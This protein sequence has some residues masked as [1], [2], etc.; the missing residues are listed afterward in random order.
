MAFAA[1][2]ILGHGF[3]LLPMMQQLAANGLAKTRDSGGSVI[4]LI[5]HADPVV[6][7]VMGI[8]A[9]ASIWSWAVAI[10]KWFTIQAAKGRAKRFESQFWSGGA[11]EDMSDRVGDK[12]SDAMARIF[13]AGSREYRDAARART[14]VTEPQAN[15]MIERAR[16]QMNVAVQRESTRLESG[17]QTLAIVA[18]SA[19]FI[20][21]FGTVI[22]IMNAFSAIGAQQQ[23]NLAVV[24]PGIAEALL[25]T[26]IGLGAAVPAL[27]F[28]NKF[29]GD[30][31]KFT[32]RL[33]LFAQEFTVR[34][35]RRLSGGREDDR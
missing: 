9:L 5:M 14:S 28:Y 31:G 29:S 24:G 34:L 11:L 17:L 8:L 27:V 26:A 2:P 35:S 30:I 7:A 15:A 12:T 23:T 32:E 13:V 21:L 20:G 33:D 25:A 4:D 6:K 10:D 1:L 22:G 3:T 18:S 19:P 16:A